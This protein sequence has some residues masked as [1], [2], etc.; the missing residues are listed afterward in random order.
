MLFRSD[1][2]SI[3]L[4]GGAGLS[5]SRISREPWKVPP[6]EYYS[7]RFYEHGTSADNATAIERD[8]ILSGEAAPAYKNIWNNGRIVPAAIPHRFGERILVFPEVAIERSGPGR[9]IDIRAGEKPVA[10]VQSGIPTHE[11]I[12]RQA[13]SAGLPVPE[14]VRRSYGLAALLMSVAAAKSAQEP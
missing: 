14:S 8:G 2:A 7:G 13:V 9:G 12:V 1:A 11:Q 4:L 10:N 3:G 6:E 5:T